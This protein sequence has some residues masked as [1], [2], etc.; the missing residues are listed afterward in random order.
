MRSSISAYFR[1]FGIVFTF[2]LVE[3][4]EDLV[5]MYGVCIDAECWYF[6]VVTREGLWIRAKSR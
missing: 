1:F 3:E 6:V 5:I 2:L 4:A